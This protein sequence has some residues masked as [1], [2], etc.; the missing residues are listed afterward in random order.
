MIPEIRSHL[1]LTDF[2]DHEA[3]PSDR[4]ELPTASSDQTI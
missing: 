1:A 4:H 3:D 2:R